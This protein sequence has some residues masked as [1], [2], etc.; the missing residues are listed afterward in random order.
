MCHLGSREKA[1]L[2]RP[3][4]AV[5]RIVHGGS[6]TKKILR[7]FNKS[8]NHKTAD[9]RCTGIVS[10]E[11]TTLEEQLVK[12]IKKS[13]KGCV[14]RKMA[15]EPQR[16]KIKDS[17]R[18]ADNSPLKRADTEDPADD[19]PKK[20]SKRMKPDLEINPIVFDNCYESKDPC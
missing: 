16:K 17:Y 2:I 1:S 20:S 7:R 19:S 8:L 4:S 11:N 14:K 6:N 10:D 13:L 5:N 9:F 3:K 15:K 18:S 12:D